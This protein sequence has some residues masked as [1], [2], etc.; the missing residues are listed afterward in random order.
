MSVLAVGCHEEIH[1]GSRL[2]LGLH[3]LLLRF[4]TLGES[5]MAAGDA[6]GMAFIHCDTPNIP[7]EHSHVWLCQTHVWLCQTH[8]W[9]ELDM[10]PFTQ[11]SRFVMQQ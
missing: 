5:G 9:S 1:V 2:H 7:E 6:R 8:V 3:R 11:Q 10:L 4:Q